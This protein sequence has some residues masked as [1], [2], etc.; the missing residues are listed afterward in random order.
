MD[1][2]LTSL[3]TSA[4]K[5][6]VN[7]ARTQAQVVAGKPGAAVDFCVLSTDPTFSNKVTDFAVCDA[8]PVPRARRVAAP[9]RRR[10]AQ[11]RTS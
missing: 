1:Q 2:W 5:A 7:D 4:P 11:P 3:V 10:R 9:G 6:F 8:G